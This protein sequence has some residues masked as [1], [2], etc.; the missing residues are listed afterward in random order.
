M[1]FDFA[2]ARNQLDITT[3]SEFYDDVYQNVWKMQIHR[4]SSFEQPT[5][6]HSSA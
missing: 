2:P 5:A 1:I 6:A 3:H 4:Q